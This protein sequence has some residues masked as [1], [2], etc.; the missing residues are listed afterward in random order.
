MFKASVFVGLIHIGKILE[1]STL[2][3]KSTLPR[4]NK[5]QVHAISVTEDNSLR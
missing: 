5:S 2:N 1:L 4:F 3:I